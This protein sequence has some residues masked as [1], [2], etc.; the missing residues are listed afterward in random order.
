M[1]IFTM[2]SSSDN[3]LSAINKRDSE[4]SGQTYSINLGSLKMSAGKIQIKTNSSKCSENASASM[5]N[6]T[7]I[8]SGEAALQQST[9]VR[10][11]LHVMQRIV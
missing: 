7:N 11:E 2:I 1:I 3:R 6:S 10:G 8:N 5:R 9:S 4:G